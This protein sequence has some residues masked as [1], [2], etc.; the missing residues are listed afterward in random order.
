MSFFETERLI[1]RNWDESD[2]QY[3]IELNR[4]EAVRKHF[5]DI[6]SKER[7]ELLFDMMQ[8]EIETKNLGLF[9][10]MLK[11]GTFIGFIGTLFIEEDAYI[12]YS[13]FY[14]IGWRLLPEYWGKGY[15][16]EGAQ[17]LLQYMQKLN[18]SYAYAYTS[19]HNHESLNVIN[20][21]NMEK[22]TIFHHPVYRHGEQLLFRREL[23]DTY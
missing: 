13:P 19:I 4:N 20:K 18:I 11:D 5:P 7:S 12:P 1:F 23:N 21:L 17:G 16:T 22:L 6:I 3:Y 8:S 15:A 9:A 14:E 2:L 10:A